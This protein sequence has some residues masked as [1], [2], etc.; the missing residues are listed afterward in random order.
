MNK[1]SGNFTPRSPLSRNNIIKLK[2]VALSQRS[3][4][5][6]W[7]LEIFSQETSFLNSTTWAQSA[8]SS[9][10]CA[11]ASVI[12]FTPTWNSSTKASTP[13]RALWT[14]KLSCG[15][16][17]GHQHL[18]KLLESHLI[19]LSL[20]LCS[21]YR[22]LDCGVL[23]SLKNSITNGLKLVVKETIFSKSTMPLPILS[24]Q[25]TNNKDLFTA[26]VTRCTP[27]MEPKLFLYFLRM[28]NNTARSG[29][30]YTFLRTSSISS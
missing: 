7:L 22:S 8:A 16:I 29:I 4:M 14:Q 25:K 15:R 30:R 11:P 18:R 20:C 2:R 9:S 26:T 5:H 6:M 19:Y 1:K 3:L 17:W 21:W 13:S 10:T 12:N 28:V 23:L 27:D 24:Y